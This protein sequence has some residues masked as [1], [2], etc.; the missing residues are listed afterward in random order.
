M[1][2]Q[3]SAAILSLPLWYQFVCLYDQ[4]LE[5]QQLLDLVVQEEEEV[6]LIQL[7]VQVL[8]RVPE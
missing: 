1:V 5:F 2:L 4:I 7:R 8:L 6:L 3:G